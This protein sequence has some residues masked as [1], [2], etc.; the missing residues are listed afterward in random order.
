MTNHDKP[1]FANMLRMMGEL[2]NKKLSRDLLA[3][4]WHALANFDLSVVRLAL[5]QHVRN[6]DIGQFM[7]K[8]AD[9][10]RLIEGCPDDHALRAWSKVADAIKHIGQ[11]SSVVFDDAL[12]HVVVNEMGGWINLCQTREEVLVFR[13]KEFAK[14]YASYAVKKPTHYPNRLI[15][16]LE[17]CNQVQGYANTRPVLCGDV[18]KSTAVYQQGCDPIQQRLNHQ[19]VLK[20]LPNDVQQ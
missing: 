16:S 7:P 13:A 15:G 18:S 8:P 6:P 12:I 9:L 4:Y 17:H 10:I 3:L 1:Q 5:N 14:R 2:Y 19:H 11:Y 20:K